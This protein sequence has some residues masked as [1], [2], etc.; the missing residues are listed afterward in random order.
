MGNQVM[1]IA[2]AAEKV[3]DEETLLDMLNTPNRR[4]PILL[5]ERRDIGEEVLTALACHSRP[6][7]RHH[8]LTYNGDRLPLRIVNELLND[9]QEFVRKKAESVLTRNTDQENI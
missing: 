4:V 2:D 6:D 1:A 9:K 5:A 3:T 7:V 8:V